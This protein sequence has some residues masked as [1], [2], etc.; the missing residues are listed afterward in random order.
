MSLTPLTIER[1]FTKGDY[2]RNDEFGINFVKRTAH[3]IDSNSNVIFHMDNVIVPDFWSQTAINILA[4]KYFRKTNVPLSW[5]D[6]AEQ[7]IPFWVSRR[8]PEKNTK[9]TGENDLRQVVSRLVGH[10]VYTGFKSGYFKDE[11]EARI[12][13]DELK[14]MV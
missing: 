4:Q 10:W 1:V 3:I 12:F 8:I 9:F 5:Y 2:L 13:Q 11:E 7:N 14:Y 6:V